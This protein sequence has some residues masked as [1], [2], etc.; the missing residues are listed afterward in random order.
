MW[1]RSQKGGDKTG[2]YSLGVEGIERGW[3]TR[4]A[5]GRLGIL[6]DDSECSGTTQNARGQLRML[7]GD[8]EGSGVLGIDSEGSGTLGDSVTRN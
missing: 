8:S 1:L 7:G 6:G 3:K 4:W 2:R 5:Q